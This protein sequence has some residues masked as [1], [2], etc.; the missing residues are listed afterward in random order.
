MKENALT[1]QINSVKSRVEKLRKENS[2][3]F[4]LFSDLHSGG[5]DDN[6]TQKLLQALEGICDSILP[7]A[8]IDLGD[9]LS[10]LGRQQHI[11]NDK[12]TAILSQLFDNIHKAV[13]CPIFLINGNHDAVGTDF[14][15]PA[16]WTRI[17]NGKYDGGRA[18]YHNNS[19]YYYVDYDSANLRMIFLSVPYDSDIEAVN[20]RPLWA[21][22]DRQ[23]EWLQRDALNTPHDVLLFSHVPFFYRY[24]G[25][26]TSMLEVWDGEK[27]AKSYISELCGWIDDADAAVS[28]IKE[29]GKVIAC[30]SGHT[31]ED[32]F[33]KPCEKRGEDI[34][35]LPCP[36]V[37]T[38]RPV[39]CSSTEND[40]EISIDILVWNPAERTA[41]IIRF[42]DGEDRVVSFN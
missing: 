38:K 2:L 39:L 19:S 31:H 42:G 30:F 32:S 20:P 28:V 29:S 33:W 40:F 14:F 4:P 3:V 25:D 11:S 1:A 10:M 37:V 24:R 12:L 36:Q 7:D 27:T 34:N 15:K 26:E 17:V 41:H 23:L 21:F 22:G 6:L 18:R 16:L 8:V 9:N 13:K 35:P 5:A